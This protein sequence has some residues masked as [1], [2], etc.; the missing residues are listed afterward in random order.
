MICL[1]GLSKLFCFSFNIDFRSYS[2]GLNLD[3][4]G[5]EKFQLIFFWRITTFTL[6]SMKSITKKSKT[7][8][9]SEQKQEV[10]AYFSFKIRPRDSPTSSMNLKLNVLNIFYIIYWS[11]KQFFNEVSKSKLNYELILKLN[12]RQQY[13]ML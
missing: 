3:I 5:K 2:A 13:N 6:L 7:D 12:F 9:R 10:S 11:L 4:D 8:W 1:F